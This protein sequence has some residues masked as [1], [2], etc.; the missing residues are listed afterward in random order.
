[1]SE[2]T[3]DQNEETDLQTA[4]DGETIDQDEANG[5]TDPGTNNPS[6][7]QSEDESQNSDGNDGLEE[8]EGQGNDPWQW[9]EIDEKTE[10]LP[11]SNTSSD[12]STTSENVTNPVNITELV[13]NTRL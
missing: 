1:M 5:P 8:S 7:T 12:N 2:Q 13:E 11:P 4:V 6:N 10:D 3:T 9:E